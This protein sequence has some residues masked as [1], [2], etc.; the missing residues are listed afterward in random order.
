MKAL[1]G[2]LLCLIFATSPAFAISGGP[3]YSSSSSYVGTYAGVL[4]GAFDPTL[5]GAN[6]S[7]SIGVFSL[8]VPTTGIGTG[9]F[10]MFTR[11][12]VFSG[13][14][15]ANANPNNSALKGVLA[16]TFNYNVQTISTDSAGVTKIITTP[17]TATVNGSMDAKLS[18]SKTARVSTTTSTI[19]KGTAFLDIEQGGVTASGD[20]VINGVIS[21]SVTGFRQSTTPPTT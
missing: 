18:T 8:G 14:I 7:N 6:S 1:L 19:I 5:Q 16:A 15:Q 11:G 10:V 3:V 21:L 20:P 2:S 12:R 13:N 9:A 17:V 4:K